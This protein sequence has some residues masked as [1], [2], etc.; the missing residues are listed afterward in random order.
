MR[1]YFRNGSKSSLFGKLHPASVH[2]KKI[3]AVDPAYI[4]I[5]HY[6]DK[7]QVVTQP[8]YK[9][10][11]VQHELIPTSCIFFFHLMI[12]FSLA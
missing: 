6:R 1:R 2:P 4:T 3:K 10:I 7:R 8:L 9:F 5:A 11:A 12:H